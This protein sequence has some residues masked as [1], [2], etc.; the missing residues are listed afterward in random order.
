MP[1]KDTQ[2]LHCP[3]YLLPEPV[4]ISDEAR[5]FLRAQQ[6]SDTE[7]TAHQPLSEDQQREQFY[8]SEDYQHLREQYPVT[9]VEQSLNGVEVEVFTPQTGI[10]PRNTDRVLVN[11]H[12]GCFM[13]GARTVS[14]LESIPIAALGRIKVI[15]VDYRLYPAHRYPAAT[16]DAVAVYKALLNDYDPSQIGLFGASAGAQLVAQT[17]AA[18]QAE[19]LPPPAAVAMI[20]E[21][22]GLHNQGDS[23]AINGAIFEAKTGLDLQQ[24][25][26]MPYFDGVDLNDARVCPGVN[27]TV[28]RQFPPT[29]L[30]SSGRDIWLS[31]VLATHRQLCRLGV[32]TELHIWEG[33]EHCFHYQ[34]ALPEAKELHQTVVRFFEQ[35]WRDDQ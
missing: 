3:A 20:A 31:P 4:F 28:M 35:H 9:V 13:H 25:I 17:L 26:A 23:I 12:G 34:C 18:L 24:A 32:P 27:D 19:Y 5:I 8:Q 14:H 7:A 1:Q 6:Q 30:A 2:T 11:F 21:G 29:L 33:L 15:S 10:A 16:E 22:A